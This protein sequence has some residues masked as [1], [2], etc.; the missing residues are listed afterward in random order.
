MMTP[1]LTKLTKAFDMAGFEIRIV[2]GAVRDCLLGEQP[3][4][5]DLCTDGRRR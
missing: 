1:T 4:D 2:G 5:I 3:K